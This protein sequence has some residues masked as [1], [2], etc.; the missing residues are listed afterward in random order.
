MKAYCDG[1]TLGNGTKDAKSYGSYKIDSQDVVR[2]KFDV[3]TNN[4]AEYSTLITL[5]EDLCEKNY[6]TDKIDIYTDSKL[7]INQIN[8]TWKINKDYLNTYAI[9]ARK[10]LNTCKAK[11]HYLPR[12]DIVK[13]LGH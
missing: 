4:K 13:I 2:L 10:L 6:R 8:G 1:G 3:D 11:L 12:E 5:L 9:E 7:I